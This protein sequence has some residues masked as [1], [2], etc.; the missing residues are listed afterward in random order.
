MSR[1]VSFPAKLTRMAAN[2]EWPTEHSM[3]AHILPNPTEV[4]HLELELDALIAG[5]RISQVYSTRVLG[6]S[7]DNTC[8]PLPAAALP[9][10]CVKI[11]SPIRCRSLA[12]DAWFYEHLDKEGLQGIITPRCFGLFESRLAGLD[13]TGLS[14]GR[15][16]LTNHYDEGEDKDWLEDDGFD[17]WY[18][19]DEQRSKS[20]S[21]WNEWKASEDSPHLTILLLE[22]MGGALSLETWDADEGCR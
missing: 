5:G 14:N 18:K 13:L 15:S 12:R 6:V 16:F 7:S 11:S 21:P 19:D 20:L 2:T 3:P 10:L 22:K 4:L 8:T 17:Y 9:E 1:V